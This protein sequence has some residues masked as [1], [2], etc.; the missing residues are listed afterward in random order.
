[1]I[2]KQTVILKGNV[3]GLD[4]LDMKEVDPVTYI[5]ITI[6]AME[7]VEAAYGK[8]SKLELIRRIRVLS[9]PPPPKEPTIY[10]TTDGTEPGQD[11]WGDIYRT[12]RC[13]RNSRR[14]CRYHD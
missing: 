8:C 10:Y 12:D 1:M 4:N 11:E 6:W 14:E 3:S 5:T 2:T 13:D 9:Y 7:T